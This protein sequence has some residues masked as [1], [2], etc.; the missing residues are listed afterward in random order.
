MNMNNGMQQSGMYMN[1]GMP[2]RNE[3]EQRNAAGRFVE[4]CGQR[5]PEVLTKQVD[6]QSSFCS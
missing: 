1:N 6:S 2:V 4:Y 5:I 3:H